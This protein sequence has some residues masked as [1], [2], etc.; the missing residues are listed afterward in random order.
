MIFNI[1]GESQKIR[2]A[3]KAFTGDIPAINQ[4]AGF[5]EGVSLA[6]RLCRHCMATSDQIQNKVC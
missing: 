2:G 1:K 3:I 4:L 6:L 5:K